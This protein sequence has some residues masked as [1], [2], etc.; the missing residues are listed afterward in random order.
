M[1]KE[2]STGKSDGGYVELK[3]CRDPASSTFDLYEFIMS[4][5]DHGD[6]EQFLLFIWNF[7]MTSAATGMIETEA[8]AQYLR[9]LFHG[10][11]LHQF[12]LISADVENMDTSLNVDYLL[13]FLAWYFFSVDPLSKQK[14]AMR[15]CM[16]KHAH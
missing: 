8:K 5:F 6:P 2:T 13:K 3:L 11:V 9:T 4:L 12:D 1:I 14:F 7:Q 16:K 15:C 10:E